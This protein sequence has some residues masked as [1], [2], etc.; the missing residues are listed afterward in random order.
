MTTKLQLTLRPSIN[1]NIKNPY[2]CVNIT[3]G[4]ESIFNDE[5]RDK[6]T[7]TT[8][9]YKD[10]ILAIEHYNKDPSDTSVDE[11]NNII[12]DKAIELCS[13][14]FDEFEVPM[15]FLYGCDYHINWNNEKKIIT[16]TLYFGF[17]GK[18]KVFRFY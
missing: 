7:F 17:N 18:Y 16:D 3:Y 14:F 10:G 5:L 2:P 8:E 11:N 1:F 15:T 9:I 4:G 6:K 13:L 12:G